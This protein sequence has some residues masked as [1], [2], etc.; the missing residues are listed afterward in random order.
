MTNKDELIT[1]FRKRRTLMGSGN[2]AQ[3][4]AYLLKLHGKDPKAREAYT[5]AS[6]QELL[7]AAEMLTSVTVSDTELRSPTTQ[8]KIT[9]T[10]ATIDIHQGPGE[11]LSIDLKKVDG[12]W[13]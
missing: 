4:R 11:E 1:A 12:E 9:D 5:Q 3:I 8:W 2:A 10:T 6:D 13:L 7:D